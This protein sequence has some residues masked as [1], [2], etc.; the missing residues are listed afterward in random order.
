MTGGLRMAVCD[1]AKRSEWLNL[2]ACVR[3]VCFMTSNEAEKRLIYDI[4]YQLQSFCPRRSKWYLIWGLTTKKNDEESCS[5]REEEEKPSK[6]RCV[7][8]VRK[9]WMKRS[10][11]SHS[12]S[13]HD[14]SRCGIMEGQSG[15]RMVLANH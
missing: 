11:Q 12:L 10:P 3:L 7:E 14:A 1:C 4:G 9:A 15:R 5:G 13:T 8:E 6:T 2:H